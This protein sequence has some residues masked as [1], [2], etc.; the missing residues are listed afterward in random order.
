MSANRWVPTQKSDSSTLEGVSKLVKSVLN[1]MTRERFEKLTTKI[2]DIEITSL[3][4][5]STVITIIIE[6]ALSEPN[7]ADVY[8]DLCRV[9]HTKMSSTWSFIHTLECLETKVRDMDLSIPTHLI[10]GLEILRNCFRYPSSS[11]RCWSIL[12]V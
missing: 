1:K 5:L 7:F 6:K 2:L 8:A 4:M 10:L 9:L 11:C 12:K 3:E